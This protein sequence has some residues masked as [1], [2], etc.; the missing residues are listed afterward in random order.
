MA[1]GQSATQYYGKLLGGAWCCTAQSGVV[2]CTAAAEGVGW[3][4][5]KSIDG[6]ISGLHYAKSRG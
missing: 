6:F 4:M 5:T 2:L 3:G 1:G